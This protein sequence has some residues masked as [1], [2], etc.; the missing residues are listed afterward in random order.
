[1]QPSDTGGCT[2]SQQG[3]GGDSV[4][5]MS[6][7]IEDD[8]RSGQ[9]L[10]RGRLG[11]RTWAGARMHV[12]GRRSRYWVLAVSTAYTTGTKR[13]NIRIY[14]AT[15]KTGPSTCHGHC[16]FHARCRRS[17]RKCQLLLLPSVFPLHLASFIR[18]PDLF[19]RRHV[20]QHLGVYFSRIT[21]LFFH[22]GCLLAA[23][24]PLLQR[25]APACLE[26]APAA[27][28][29]RILVGY[30]LRRSLHGYPTGPPLVTA[31]MSF[32]VCFL[33]RVPGEGFA[34]IL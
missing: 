33:A 26:R 5:S 12:P 23:F 18:K 2:G 20:R 30:A 29:H 28:W 14:S 27:A 6:G 9:R 4:S 13:S 3:S 16:S 31:C 7:S 32:C 1:M 24:V 22:I 19:L 8:S 34:F 21:A 15:I 10:D 25:S 11:L 17:A